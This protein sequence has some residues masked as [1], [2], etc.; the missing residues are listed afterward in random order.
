M[1]SPGLGFKS[2][3]QWG[4]ETTY[5]TVAAATK[6]IGILRQNISVQMKQ[7]KSG[8]LTGNFIR[9]DIYNVQQ[10]TAGQIE[11]YLTYADLQM[12]FDGLMGT[13]TFASNGGT[14]TGA[15]P[16]THVFTESHEFHNSFTLELIEGNIP[17]SKCQR[18]LG[19]KIT[20]VTIR[21]EA[22]DIVHCTFDVVGQTYQDNQT[23]TGA[24]SANTPVMVLT[25]HGS[26]GDTATAYDGSGDAAANLVLKS[27]ELTIKNMI[28][29]SRDIVGLS[30]IG[31]PIRNGFPM[32]QMKFHREFRTLASLDAYIART[33]QNPSLVF[34]NTS[35]FQFT[36]EMDV[37][38]VVDENH[39][40]D[41]DGIIFQDVTLEAIFDA[42]NTTGSKVSIKNTQS[43]I[44]T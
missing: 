35:N 2:Y 9:Q 10:K 26:V 1:A 44:T 32:S 40:I 14:T 20:G 43:T 27:F 18:I 16:Y 33:N 36:M 13:N 19:A 28:D 5:G 23:P 22:N 37:A 42:G 38:A 17:A 12:L 4:R 7:V 15:N 25:Q 41:S 3:L 34:T 11:V 8:L 39:G 31:E 21:G 6:R 30:T 29:E 24:L